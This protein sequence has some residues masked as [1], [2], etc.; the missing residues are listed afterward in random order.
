MQ[1][2]Q[3]LLEK[4]KTIYLKCKKRSNFFSYLRLFSILAVVYNFYLFLRKEEAIYGYISLGFVV[5]FVV[6]LNRYQRIAKQLAYYKAMMQVNESEIKFLEGNGVTFD[7]GS[8]YSDAQHPY[9]YDL[10]IFGTASLFQYVNRTAS[11]IGRHSLAGLFKDTSDKKSIENKQAAI[12]ELSTAID[13]RQKIN[14]LTLISKDQK[15][16]FEKLQHWCAQE[17]KMM[18]KLKVVMS[19]VLPVL[20]LLSAIFYYFDAYPLLGKISSFLFVLNLL[21][22]SMNAR[23]M[24]QE[25]LG[26]DKIAA[27]LSNYGGILHEIEKKQFTSEQLIALQNELRGNQA[28]SAKIS[29]LSEHFEKLETIANLFIAVAFN[30]VF[31]YHNHVLQKLLQWKK[32]HRH[33][34][35]RWLEIVGEIEALNSLANFAYNNPTYAYP[36]INEAQDFQFTALGHPLIAAQKRV[37]ND[38]DLSEHR[39]VILTGSNMSGK[40]TFLRKSL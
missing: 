6:L 15:S 39:F 4:Y 24:Q 29:V 28:A 13:W 8:E 10:D 35:M 23:Q 18:S 12:A 30:G 1:H 36:K 11:Y 14:A 38:I 16:D 32:M 19:Y 22:F 3:F 26:S 40:S 27:T 31:Q 9:T 17:P 2:Y 7:D 33:E 34:L 5:V 25:I 20:F 37:C 21:S